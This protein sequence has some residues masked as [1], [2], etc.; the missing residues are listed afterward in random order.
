MACETTWSFSG[1]PHSDI[2]TSSQV[3]F[4]QIVAA[5]AECELEKY[6]YTISRFTGILSLQ[7][8]KKI[9]RPWFIIYQFT[10][11]FGSYSMISYAIDQNTYF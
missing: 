11:Y 6:S 9:N 2:G 7:P 8:L 3:I 5:Q 10:G 4:H 1:T